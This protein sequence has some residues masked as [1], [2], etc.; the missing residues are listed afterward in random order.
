MEWDPFR[1]LRHGTNTMK[2]SL[3]PKSRRRGSIATTCI[4]VLA[5]VGVLILAL[6]GV[7]ASRSQE[8]LETERQ[9]VASGIAESALRLAEVKIWGGYQAA[10]PE[11][12]RNVPALQNYLDGL[13]IQRGSSDGEPGSTVFLES[14][15]VGQDA[16]GAY[17]FGGGFVLELNVERRDTQQ[18]CEIAILV[19]ASMG[20]DGPVCRVRKAYDSAGQEQEE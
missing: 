16:G 12:D 9:A 3:H 10:V 19:A 4:A 1:F 7:R 5:V 18:A 17:P 2:T 11:S 20:E 14:L 6:F 15:G 13:G 8:H